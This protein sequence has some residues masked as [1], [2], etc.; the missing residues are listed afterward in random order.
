MSELT[1]GPFTCMKDVP[2]GHPT[3]GSPRPLKA[4]EVAEALEPW[5][6]GR[7]V[8]GCVPPGEASKLVWS[9]QD[10]E[11]SSPLHGGGPCLSRC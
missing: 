4:L 1:P 8:Q 10:P 6:G 7:V 11:E 2:S 3:G 9:A 5:R